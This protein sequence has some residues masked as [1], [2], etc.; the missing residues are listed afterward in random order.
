MRPKSCPIVSIIT[1]SFNSEKYISDTI[2][3]VLRQTYPYIE[4]LIIDGGSTDSTLLISSRYPSLKVFSEPD[5][6]IYDAMNKGI[7][8]S[9]GILLVS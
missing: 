2:E 8:F 3:S 5:Q 4:H 1:V 7:G 6:G 9:S